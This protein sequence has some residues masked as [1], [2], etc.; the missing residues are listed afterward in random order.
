MSRAGDFVQLPETE[1]GY[2]PRIDLVIGLSTDVVNQDE[3][4]IHDTDD[5]VYWAKYAQVGAKDT[6]NYKLTEHPTDINFGNLNK[7]AMQTPGG[8]S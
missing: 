7:S 5:A 1:S 4:L 3:V 8:S 2:K 6:I